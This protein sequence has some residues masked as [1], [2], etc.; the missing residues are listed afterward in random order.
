MDS[1]SDTMSDQLSGKISEGDVRLM[2]G[3]CQTRCQRL[4]EGM[5]E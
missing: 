3:K 4:L 5:P 2:S 1:K